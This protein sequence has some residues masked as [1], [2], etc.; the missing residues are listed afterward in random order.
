MKL[1]IVEDN[2][3]MRQEL[4]TFLGDLAEEIVH[5]ADGAEALEAY[6][7]HKPDWVLMDIVMKEVDGLKATR[8]IK[9]SWPSARIVIVTSYDDQELKDAASMAGAFAY[10]L[11]ENLSDLRE[12]LSNAG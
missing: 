5:C 12:I 3:Q 1:L 4:A 7:F 2:A 6:T 9:T 8:Q 10:V 11:K